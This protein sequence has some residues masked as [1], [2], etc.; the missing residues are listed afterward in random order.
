MKKILLSLL[1]I[2]P[3]IFIGYQAGELLPFGKLTRL[4]PVLRF[5]WF[6]QMGWTMTEEAFNCNS[7]DAKG[8]LLTSKKN[9]ELAV[10]KMSDPGFK[11]DYPGFM[12]NTMLLRAGLT[13][14]RLAV[15]EEEAGNSDQAKQYLSN[16]QADLKAV[17]WRDNSRETI[18]QAAKKYRIRPSKD[19]NRHPQETRK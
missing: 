2:L 19:A 12:K 17:G 13:N 14:A 16:A 6:S 11:L 9:F 8:L 1:V 18:F 5:S 15:L 10:T 4:D 7:S 3:G